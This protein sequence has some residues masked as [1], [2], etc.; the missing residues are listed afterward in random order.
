MLAGFDRNVALELDQRGKPIS[1]FAA[2]QQS[3]S[4]MGLVARGAIE[5]LLIA[6]TFRSVAAS[7]RKRTTIVERL[8]RVVQAHVPWTGSPRNMSPFVVGHPGE[9]G[10]EFAATGRSGGCRPPVP[11]DLMRSSRPALSRSCAQANSA[12]Q[13]ISGFSGAPGR[14]GSGRTTFAAA[15]AFQGDFEFAH[16]G[17]RAFVFDL[18]SLFTAREPKFPKWAFSL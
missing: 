7:A 15:A 16:K 11:P 12:I 1:R 18:K 10:R 13:R 5:R 8:S 6:T 2:S 9:R 3:A 14:N 4:T 17:L